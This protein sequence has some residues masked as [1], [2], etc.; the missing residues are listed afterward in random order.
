MGQRASY[1]DDPALADQ[2]FEL[3]ELPFPGVSRGRE[4]AKAF[5]APWEGASTPFVVRHGDRV[6][7]H[8]GLLS[9]PLRVMSEDVLVGGVHGVATHPDHRRRGLFRSLIEEVIEFAEPRFAA[10]MLTTLHP[11]Y[12]EAFGF[13]VI[14]EW[15]GH[16]T[17]QPTAP[18]PSRPLDLGVPEDLALVHE[19]I[20]RRTPVSHQLGV[21]NEKACWGFVEFATPI[22]YASSLG[23]AVVGERSG[24]TLRVYDLLGPAIP[25]LDEIA[26][27]WG[28][29]VRRVLLFFATDR[30]AGVWSTEPHDLSGGEDALEPGTAGW[31]MMARGRF[32]AEG[33]PIMLPRPA[34][35]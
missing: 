26:A 12:F 17:P 33:R 20:D 5:G 14:P 11:E 23:V 1:R 27:I 2:I 15:V 9:I 8:V 22:R 35:C 24:D 31:V 32:A 10:L 18:I 4:H 25:S 29:G 16:G 13:R 19:L 6:L 3:L 21:G 30:V 34:R 7:S 28:D